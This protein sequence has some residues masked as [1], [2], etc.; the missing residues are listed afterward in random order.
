MQFAFGLV[1]HTLTGGNRTGLPTDPVFPA[2]GSSNVFSTVEFNYFPN[3]SPLYG[4]PTLTPSVFGAQS[5]GGDAFGN[6]T[7]LFGSGPDLGDNVVPA[8]I[9]QLPQSVL[10]LATL[11]FSASTKLLVLTMQRIN[12]DLSLTTLETGVPALDLSFVTP[13]FAVDS[14]A[15]MAYGDGY[16]SA[17]TAL[18]GDMDIRQIAVSSPVPEPATGLLFVSAGGVLALFRRRRA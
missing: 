8:Q 14:L 2:P 6:F 12:G 5:A 9:D 3:V 17:P 13:T 4:G 15:I 11:D 18:V 1:N 7:S 16:S 10:L